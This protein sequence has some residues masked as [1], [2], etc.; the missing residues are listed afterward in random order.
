MITESQ[1]KRIFVYTTSPLA[2]V[3]WLM[4]FTCK[5]TYFAQL[6]YD[7]YHKVMRFIINILQH[8][9]HKQSHR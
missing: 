1:T 8:Y 7:L 5:L 4:F 3:V 6:S 9:M 2:R